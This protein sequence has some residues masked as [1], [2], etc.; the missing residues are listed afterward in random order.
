QKETPPAKQIGEEVKPKSDIKIE[1]IGKKIKSKQDQLK[2]ECKEVESKK[3]IIEKIN[4]PELSKEFLKILNENNN[5]LLK[6]DLINILSAFYKTDESTIKQIMENE[7]KNIEEALEYAYIQ[8]VREISNDFSLTTDE[9]FNKIIEIYNNQI[10]LDTRTSESIAKQQYSTPLPISFLMNKFL[11]PDKYSLVF[12]P[13][14][15]NGALILNFNNENVIA[16][17]LDTGART[18]NLKDSNFGLILNEDATV[19]E[20]NKKVDFVIANPPFGNLETPVKFE[21]FLIKKLEHLII[22]QALKQ[23]KNS[24]K[25][26]FIIGGNSF[27]NIFGKETQN[28]SEAD[29]IFFNYLY[30]RYNVD[31]HINVDGKIYEKQGTTFPIRIIT[32]NGRKATPD[33]NFAPT[34]LSEIKNVKNFEELKEVLLKYKKISTE[35]KQDDTIIDTNDSKPS[36]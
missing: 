34:N 13:T 20:L 4:T 8:K 36:E 30:S 10:K 1:D 33:K 28:L 14:A 16:N 22:L 6:K 15:G 27:K 24:G 21:G 17:E 5:I 11:N 12:E 32:I 26:A 23:M 9:Q 18:Q 29:R 31:N 7:K 19:L 35:R 25:A 3:E 2:E